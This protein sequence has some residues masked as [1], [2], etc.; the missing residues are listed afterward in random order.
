MFV[1]QRIERGQWR[2]II[3]H[4]EESVAREIYERNKGVKDR[5]GGWSW[6]LVRRTEET[7]EQSLLGV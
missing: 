3:S 2:D 5:H 6:R 7:L 4:E 1:V